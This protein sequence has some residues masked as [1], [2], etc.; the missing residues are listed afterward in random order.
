MAWHR[1]HSD[2]RD[3][4]LVAGIQLIAGTIAFVVLMLLFLP[5]G[6]IGPSDATKAPMISR[7]LAGL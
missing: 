1:R 6:T 2:R 4:A 5:G 7:I 3:R